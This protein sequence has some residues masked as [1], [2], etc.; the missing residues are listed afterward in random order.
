MYF[1]TFFVNNKNGEVMNYNILSNKKLI[2]FMSISNIF[3]INLIGLSRLFNRFKNVAWLI[4]LI[5]IIMVFIICL[6]FKGL[7]KE[8]NIMKKIRKKYLLRILLLIYLLFSITFNTVIVSLT[9]NKF[10]YFN[11]NVLITSFCILFAS[12]ILSRNSFN[13]IISLSMIFFIFIIII[14]II[15]FTHFEER[16]FSLLFPIN[17][18]FK[19]LIYTIPLL[20][21]PLEHLIHGLFNNQIENGFTKKSLIIS[22][23]IEGFY[24]L[25]IMLDAQTLVGAN[26]YVDMYYPGVFRWLVY[27]GNKFIENY[28]IFLL[29]IIITTYIF[30][31]SFY[32]HTLRKILF[33]KSKTK[34]YLLIFLVSFTIISILYIL[35]NYLG[36]ISVVYIYTS[37]GI[38]LILYLYFIY[39]SHKNYLKGKNNG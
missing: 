30:K 29:I 15:P 35:N 4:V 36:I 13:K 21:F 38:L 33:I 1:F 19:D 9:I 2:L 34:N 27:Q 28:D 5:M 26:F 31:L 12:L 6:P 25:F 37:L 23:I 24:I 10:F 20:M 7:P 8:L 32:L 14:Y 22:C 17:I 11:T 3:I 16:E 39:L 18:N